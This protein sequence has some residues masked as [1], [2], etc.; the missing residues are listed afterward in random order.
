MEEDTTTTVISE[1][2]GALL[3]DPDPFSYFM[4]VAFEASG[5]FR[6]AVLLL[7]WPV[8]RTLELSGKRDAGL[9]LM[10][11]TAVVGLRES[12]IELVARAVLPKFYMDDLNVDSWRVFGSSGCKR[13][14]VVT[15]MPRIMVERFVKDHLMA[16]EVIG[17]ELKVGLL[18]C[19]TGFIKGE[20]GSSDRMTQLLDKEGNQTLRVV[21]P[22]SASFMPQYEGKMNQPTSRRSGRHPQD[23]MQLSPNPVIFHDGRLVKRP[24]PSTALF[25]LLWLPIGIVLAAIRILIGLI[26]PLTVVPY[27]SQIFGGNIIVHGKPPQPTANGRTGVLF[28]CTH[29]TLMDPRCSV[30]CP[31]AKDPR[32]DLLDLEIVRDPVA[33]SHRTIDPGPA[34]RC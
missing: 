33:H 19:A 34:H 27:V 11:F 26:I 17:S 22:S 1:L 28:V 6:F 3:N 13:R 5:I 10:T 21:G 32:A 14:V 8:I 12:E 2:E 25:I 30:N 31:K 23:Q 20:I 9:R 18:G 4:L 15:R 24:T 29:R 7:L 16:D